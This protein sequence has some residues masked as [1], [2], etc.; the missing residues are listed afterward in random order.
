MDIWD[1]VGCQFG[2][3]EVDNV[4]VPML[5]GERQSIDQIVSMSQPSLAETRISP[6]RSVSS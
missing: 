1:A 6:L 5:K 3:S 4:P 2:G